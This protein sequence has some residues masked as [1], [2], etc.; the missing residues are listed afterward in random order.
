MH[1]KNNPEKN[2]FKPQRQSIQGILIIFGNSLQ[3]IIRGA[4]PFLVITIFKYK[5]EKLPFYLATLAVILVLG[6][7][8]AYLS[9]LKFTFYFD[10]IKKEFVVNKGILKKTKISIPVE[11][12]QQVNINQS[13]IQKLVNVYSLQIDTAGSAT[14]E[15][16]ISAI[17]HDLALQLKETLLDSDAENHLSI[18]N[19]LNEISKKPFL[20]LNLGML[21]KIGLTTNYGRSIALL[22][23]FIVATYNGLRDIIDSMEINTDEISSRME[24]GFALFSTGIIV[25]LVLFLVLSINLVRSIYKFY[26]FEMTKNKHSLLVSS[27]LLAKKQTLLRPNKVQTTQYSQNYFQK[28][29]QFFDMKMK[30]ASST[31]PSSNV[32]EES[33]FEVPGCN[34]D[35][36][37]A[38]LKM[39]LKGIPK[40][41]LTIK[42]NFRYLIRVF[43]FAILIPSCIYFVLAFQ[44]DEV[45]GLIYFYFAYV[46]LVLLYS[47]FRFKNNLLMIDDQYIMK[48][49][50][51]W[52]IQHDIIEVHKIQGIV[53]KQYIWNRKNNLGHLSLFTAGGVLFFTFAPFDLLKKLTNQWLHKVEISKKS[54][55]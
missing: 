3:K 10:Q 23:G 9:Y 12:I 18:N 6:A 20:K 41:N 14:K 26:E 30:Q 13:I 40:P 25:G 32:K 27:G 24:Q 7:V 39:I 22:F 1:H 28:K 8:I 45:L 50:G 19:S 37:D 47:F 46:F 34:V 33:S 21:L 16:E 42:S 15:V 2:I 43:L 31:E 53:L 5:S 55:M 51:A 11:K 48:K 54:W 38:I 36:R 35:Q 29:W 4:W 44:S 52:D 49:S 17:P